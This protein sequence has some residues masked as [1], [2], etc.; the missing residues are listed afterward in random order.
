M[1]NDLFMGLMRV[2]G[3]I[4][5]TTVVGRPAYMTF[6]T[7]ERRLNGSLEEHREIRCLISF[8]GYNSHV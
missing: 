6:I 4:F 3:I 1:E 8:I 7:L 5:I 2:F